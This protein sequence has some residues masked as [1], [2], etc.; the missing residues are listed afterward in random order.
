ML[1]RIQEA[2][3]VLFASPIYFYHLPAHF[4]ALVD[5]A[6]CLWEAAVATKTATERAGSR[7]KDALALLTAGRVRGAHL[8]SG[9]L[10][11]LGHF[12]ATW[13]AVVRETRLLRGVEQVR[14]LRERPATTASLRWW[15]YDW[16]RRLAAAPF[17]EKKVSR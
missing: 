15:G 9:A 14:N 12:A 5:R 17:S 1:L 7:G 2:P 13:G 6:Q 8:F 3:L 10:L 11:T 16:G 4:K